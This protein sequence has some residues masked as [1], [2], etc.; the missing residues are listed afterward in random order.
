[1]AEIKKAHEVRHETHHPKKPAD[2]AQGNAQARLER[3]ERNRDEDGPRLSRGVRPRD[4]AD[5]R[6]EVER[7]GSGPSWLS[8]LADAFGNHDRDAKVCRVPQKSADAK[9]IDEIAATQENLAEGS[10]NRRITGEY[11]RQADE[12]REFLGDDAGASWVNYAAFASNQVGGGIRGEGGFG[13]FSPNDDQRRALAEGNREVFAEIAPKFES[14]LDQFGGAQKKDPQQLRQ[15]LDENFQRGDDP[16][17]GGQDRLRDA[18]ENYYNA[19]WESDVQKKQELTALANIQIAEH[20]QI[21]LDDKLD[22]ALKDPGGVNG[23]VKDIGNIFGG[24]ADDK[25]NEQVDLELAG[26]RLD[27]D[28]NV[29]ESRDPN[30]RLADFHRIQNRELRE[31]IDEWRE[32]GSKSDDSAS[33][34][35]SDA[36]PWHDLDERMYYLAQLMRTQHTNPALFDFSQLNT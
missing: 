30:N 7:S 19:K 2:L 36:E 21:R 15:W 5:D 24:F 8:S 29:P 11:A 31:R 18:F 35:G 34:S 33:L 13:P 32:R 20:E 1:M 14:F 9:R 28:H 26:G 4:K 17:K 23:V 25:I 27:V 12:M 3:S 6:V 16:N 22:Q 10:R